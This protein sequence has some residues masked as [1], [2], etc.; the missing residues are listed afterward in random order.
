MDKATTTTIMI[1][2]HP[3][4]NVKH[5]LLQKMYARMN[6]G[7]NIQ[8]SPQ[9]LEMLQ[10]GEEISFSI[11]LEQDVERQKIDIFR[12]G[13]PPPTLVEG[14][15]M[16]L[17]FFRQQIE[18]LQSNGNLRT[19]ETYQ[20]AHNKFLTFRQGKDIAATEIDG[21]MME[22]LQAFLRLQGLSMNSISFYLR[23]IRAVYHRAVEQGLCID[24]HPFTH[25]FTGSQTTAKRA[26]SLEELRRI[27]KLVLTNTDEQ[28]AQD[29]FLFSFYTRGMSFVD[30]AYL[31]KENVHDGMMVYTRR[32]T[33]QMLAV[34]WETV[35]QRIVDRHPSSTPYLLPIIHTMGDNER[36]QY[37]AVQDRVNRLLK[38]IAMKANIR[39]NLTMYC[40]RHSWA[41]I[42]R[43]HKI[44]VSV[45][46]HAMGHA[47]EQT[48]EVYLKAIDSSIIDQ[49]NYEMIGL[50]ENRCS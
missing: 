22:A 32:K 48:T 28:F 11:S 21:A 7:I 17:E 3:L 29:L 43:E 5:L 18:R 12:S 10:R 14:Q 38:N 39:Q 35:M 45:I 16:F 33:G 31:K 4:G 36:N 27:K 24:C 2:P 34:R 25:V 26:L 9:Q 46:S 20:A 37:R 47:N 23:I 30:L 42:A 19:S 13:N 15:T 41:T 6:T 50:L 1:I 40:A 49:C 44:P 8:L